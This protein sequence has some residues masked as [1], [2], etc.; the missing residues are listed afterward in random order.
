MIFSWPI[1]IILAIVLAIG[2]FSVAAVL[3][4][5]AD[6]FHSMGFFKYIFIL[7]GVFLVAM[8]VPPVRALL[9]KLGIKVK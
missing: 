5:L 2:G 4:N 7:I 6:L 3:G 9:N 8:Y 1:A